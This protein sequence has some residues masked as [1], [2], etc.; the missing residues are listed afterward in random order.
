MSEFGNERGGKRPPEMSSRWGL[1]RRDVGYYG[2]RWR[3]L[4]RSLWWTIVRG[5]YTESCQECGRP[6]RGFLWHAP[7]PLY[8]ELTGSMGGTFCPRC[9]N[10]KARSAGIWVDWTPMVAAGIAVDPSML[11]A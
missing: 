9:F 11:T 10:E 8:L 2:K 1:A 4:A 3:A 6:Y 7:D 5:H